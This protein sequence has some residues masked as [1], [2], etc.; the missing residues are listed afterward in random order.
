M[1]LN[2][3][4]MQNYEK[5][6]VLMFDEV[7]VSSTMEYD[8]LKDEVISPHNQLQVVMAR[9]IAS[10][11]KQPVYVGFDQKMTKEILYDIIKRLN[12]INLKQFVLSVTV[13][14][15]TLVYGELSI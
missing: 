6:T 10:Q 9:G 13:E 14:V 5:M 2:G 12:D 8:V 4:N 15:E 1:K 11:W 3:D 7:K